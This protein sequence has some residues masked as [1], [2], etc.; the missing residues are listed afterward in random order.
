MLKLLSK[1]VFFLLILAFLIALTRIEA[2]VALIVF[3]MSATLVFTIVPFLAHR[4]KLRG[5][6]GKDMNKFHKPEVPEMGGIAVMLGFFA[7]VILALVYYAYLHFFPG[8]NLTALLAGLL[9]ITLVGFLGVLDDLVGWKQGIRQWQHAIV[10]VFAALPLMALPEA[11]GFTSISVP[12]FGAVQLGILYSLVLVPI[13]ITGAS[14]ASN[15]LA[16]F[17]G[18][19]AGMGLINALT[20]LAVAFILGEMEAVILMAGLAGA[21]AAFLWFNWYPAKIFPGDSLTLMTGAGIAAAVIIGNMEKIGIMLFALYFVEFAFKAKHKFQSECFGIPQ[22]DGTLK[23]SPKGGSVTHWIM[24]HGKFTE[25]QVTG[26]IL[27]VQG[28]IALIVFV[29]FLQGYQLGV[30]QGFVKV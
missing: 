13:G 12:F 25:P 14:N 3:V 4:M 5:I 16:G 24:K 29:L 15:M 22:A 27:T 9:T 2:L 6:V 19:E 18:L 20:V 28:I 30:S 21:L 10:P 7:S 26:I 23:A 1:R 8:L 11:V 17:N